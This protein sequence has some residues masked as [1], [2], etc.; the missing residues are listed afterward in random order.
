MSSSPSLHTLSVI[1]LTR[2]FVLGFVKLH[3]VHVG[4]LLKPVQ[5]PLDSIPF[6]CHISC[7]THLD[8]ICKFAECTINLSICVIGKD[9]KKH[10]F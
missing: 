5:V 2:V 8:V 9:V 4:P 3:Y 6:S 10:R 7:A 1:V